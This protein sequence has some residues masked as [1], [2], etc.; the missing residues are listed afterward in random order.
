[1]RPLREGARAATIVWTLVRHRVPG[2]L[3]RDVVR[4]HLSNPHCPC[5]ADADMTARARRM[6]H[7]LERLGPAFVKLGQFLSRRPDLLPAPYL[8]ELSS[9]QEHTPPIPFEAARATLESVC[10]C[11]SAHGDREEGEGSPGH[12]H[13]PVTAC[14]HCR[15]V[16][17]VFDRFDPEPVA[18]ASLAQV[19]RA[20]YRGRPVA[21][22]FLRP[23]VLD[24]L[25]RDLELL[26]RLRWVTGRLLGLGRNMDPEELIDEFARRLREEVNLEN[27]ALNIDRFRDAHPDDGE[28]GAPAVYWEFRRSDVLVMDFAEGRSLRAWRGTP[29][30]RRRLAGVL[31]RDFVRQVFVHNLFHADPHPG[32]LVVDA[33]GRVTYLDFGTVG[34]LEP[35]ARKGLLRLLR[36]ILEDDAELAVSAV[37]ELG[38]TD[39]AT[40]DRAV[41]AAD[42]D[43]IIQLYRRRAGLRW[44][45]EVVK[46]ARRHRIRLPRS[47]LLYAKATVLSESLV[48]ELDPE[49]EVLPVLTEALG[50]VLR[51]ELD[52]RLDELRRTLPELVVAYT[53]LARRL[54]RLI[55]GRLARSARDGS[56]AGSTHAR[57]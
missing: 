16:P 15:G 30:E 8:D 35:P 9:L 2:A 51:E 22:K 54:P 43:R 19:H 29:S 45:D 23:A 49:F 37:L 12:A 21:V 17:G 41:L 26:R 27:E 31:S 57:T 14:L 6:R 56:A 46:V 13:D 40:V 36:A 7:A 47:V 53:E 39:P 33:G 50:P 34:R 48:T 44:T 5:E 24:L 38:G 55:E 32:N 11:P 1:V 52:R 4:S 25:N 18:S 10:V 3:Y 42:I 28:V 20:T